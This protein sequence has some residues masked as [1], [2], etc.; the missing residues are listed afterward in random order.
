MLNIF[1]CAFCPF[2]F[3]L[4]KLLVFLILSYMCCLC[5]LEINPLFIASFANIFSHSMSHHFILF[6]ISFAVKKLLSLIM[7]HLFIFISITLG[8]GLKKVLLRFMSNI[9]PMFSSKCHIVS[10]LTIKVS[11]PF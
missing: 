6:M 8:D 10:G 1:S 2:V 3:L 11:N 9:L 5:I 4:W 7:S